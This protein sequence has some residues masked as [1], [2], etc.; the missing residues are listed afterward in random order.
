MDRQLNE[1]LSGNPSAIK[2]LVQATNR[3]LPSEEPIVTRVRPETSMGIT[4][5]SLANCTVPLYGRHPTGRW[6]F[7]VK[8]VLADTLT[9]S[10]VGAMPTGKP[11]SRLDLARY[12]NKPDCPYHELP[13]A[14]H[15]NS[16]NLEA[17]LHASIIFASVSVCGG[18]ERP[19]PKRVVSRSTTGV[20]DA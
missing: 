18:V 13:T 6:V 1:L 3:Q 17:S 14:M 5:L 11:P 7:P 9:L 12:L 2:A 8:Q 10:S 20:V 19:G 4:D 15:H 16:H